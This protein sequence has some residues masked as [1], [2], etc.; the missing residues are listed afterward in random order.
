MKMNKTISFLLLIAGIVGMIGTAIA[1][2]PVINAASI[3]VSNQIDTSVTISWV[4][5]AASNST[6]RVYNDSAGANLIDTF[7]DA[8]TDDLHRVVCLG[9]HAWTQYWY[10]VESANTDGTTVD[11]NSGNYHT[12]KTAGGAGSVKDNVRLYVKN[13]NGTPARNGVLVYFEVTHGGVTSWLLSGITGYD[14]GYAV[15]NLGN[16]KNPSNGDSLSYE[17]GDAIH[18]EAW[19]GA[20]GYGE[21]DTTIPS[22][23]WLDNITLT[24]DTAAPAITNVTKTTPTTSSVTITWDTDESSDS[25]VKYGTASG[26]YPYNQS[27]TT[28]T[29]SH[30]ITLTGLSP[31]TNYYFVVNSTDASGNSNESDEYSFETAAYPAPAITGWGN[32]KTNNASTSITV[33][34]SESVRFN[35]T[36]NQTITTWKW[37]KDGANQSNNFD[38]YT[39]SW[40]VN[41]TNNVTVNATN[42]N[43]TS[44]TTTWTITVNDIMPPEIVTG[45]TNDTPTIS[46]VNLSWAA[47]SESDLAGYYVYQDGSLLGNTSSA[48]TYWNVTG[49]SSNTTYVFNVSAYDDN[50][51]EGINASVTVT[52]A[53]PPAITSWDNNKTNDASTDITINESEAVRFNATAD[54][55][56]TVWNW[57][58]DGTDQSHNFD[59]YTASWSVNETYSVS[60][61]ATNENGTSNTKSWTITVNDITPSASITN[62][63]NTTYETYIN[64]TWTDPADADLS[65]VMV[66]IN[67]TFKA[68]VTKGVQFYNATGLTADTTYKISTRTVDDAGNINNTWV[69]DTAKTAP[70]TTPSASITNLQNTTYEQTYINWTWTDPAD[71]DF[72]KVMVYINGTFKTNVTNVTQFYN[73]TELAANTTY[74]ISTCTVD[75][76]GNI[77]DTWVN[78]TAKTAPDTTPPVAIIAG[79]DGTVNVSETVNFDG[80]GSS[81]N[82]DEIVSYEWDFGDG[83]ATDGAADNASH[84][85]S[86]AG[87]Y[88]VALTVYDKANNSDTDTCRVS[89]IA[90][91]TEQ[92]VTY[93][94][95]NATTTNGNNVTIDGTNITGTD[96]LN[97]TVRIDLDN[98]TLVIDIEVNTTAN[99]TGTVTSVILD[100]PPVSA[101]Q[102]LNGT[103]DV[104]LNLNSSVWTGKHN[105]QLALQ[106]LNS[107]NDTAAGWNE[108]A[109]ANATAAVTLAMS[110]LGLSDAETAIV[111]NAILSGINESDVLSL[112]INMTVDGAWYREVADSKSANVYLFKFYNNGTEK[113]RRNP[114]SVHHDMINDTYTFCFVMEGFSTFALVGGTVSGGDG[115]GSSSTGGGDGTYPPG[116]FGTPT[117][118]VTATTIPAAS[119]TATDAPPGERVTPAPTK[120][121]PATVKTDAS[122]AEGT[123]AGAAKKGAPGFTAVFV[124]AGM[125]AVAYAM[126][127]RRE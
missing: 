116:W 121:K 118:T 120:A 32:D 61:N 110:G 66:Y 46:T 74:E 48:I 86:T 21:I 58:R 17:V 10:E 28:R 41:G 78:D 97:D 112:P 22:N 35:A 127:R 99:T 25:L 5:D 114:T 106:P 38:N 111:V 117:P 98:G 51:L 107:L 1:A 68:N 2:P 69:N 8:T 87:I 59:S 43:G 70:D 12:F 44:D 71:A 49:L 123:T 24:I 6:V 73:A 4:T 64:W 16:L 91:P 125:L 39:T 29:T 103:A 93:N 54:Q 92:N 30:T 80:S 36:A 3:N 9:L 89:V 31:D 115:G 34:E 11:N 62:L 104:D 88:T 101:N 119:A 47:N 82:S 60:V 109:A 65:K 50:G 126:M 67:G 94:V 26:S 42:D 27:N 53:P 20:A 124:I 40:S 95:T 75:D 76:A 7:T 96:P 100:T 63:Q 15:V 102:S 90:L 85:Y 52:T 81:D 105:P 108:T 37:F 56:I 18:V 84:I 14:A 122:A 57:F 45:L 113:Q 19:A 79:P 23:Y 83:N 77:N 72:S 33:N 55:V 13:E